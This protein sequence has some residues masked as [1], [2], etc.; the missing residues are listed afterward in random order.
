MSKRDQD[1]ETRF[2][3]RFLNIVLRSMITV[4]FDTDVRIRLQNKKD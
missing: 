3:L 4:V 2:L 1:G